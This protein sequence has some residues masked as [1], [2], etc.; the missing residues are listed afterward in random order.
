M[1]DDGA[2]NPEPTPLPVDP[3]LAAYVER[4]INKALGEALDNVRDQT[5]EQRQQEIDRVEELRALVS[6]V[7]AMLEKFCRLIE[8]ERSQRAILDL[9]VPT[10]RNDVN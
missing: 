3:A 5:R 1:R 7:E 8:A 10:R 9:P 4:T 6:R 2:M